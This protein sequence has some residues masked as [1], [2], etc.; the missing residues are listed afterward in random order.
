V[1]RGPGCNAKR[2]TSSGRHS[3]RTAS[4]LRRLHR[5]DAARLAYTEAMMLATSQAERA[6]LTERLSKL[7]ADS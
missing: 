5:T 3:R 2:I 6:L 7:D 4:F 1:H